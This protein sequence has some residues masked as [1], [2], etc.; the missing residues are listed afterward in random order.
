MK[1]IAELRKLQEEQLLEKLK[2]E[3]LSL[4]L[5]A[6]QSHLNKTG[7]FNLDWD[8]KINEYEQ[9]AKEEEERIRERHQ[10]EMNNVTIDQ[11]NEISEKPRLSAKVLSLK[12][13][14]VNLAKQKE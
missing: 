14:Q 10:E 11:K 13:I 6:E 5:K 2:S 8:N 12:R 1:K 3:H 9:N 4:K 7:E